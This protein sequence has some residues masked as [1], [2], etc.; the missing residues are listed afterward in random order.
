MN[1]SDPSDN[2]WCIEWTIRPF[3]IW[4]VV[5]QA[6]FWVSYINGKLWYAAFQ[7]YIIYMCILSIW[8]KVARPMISGALNGP[9]ICLWYDEW[10]SKLPKE[11]LISM[12]SCDMQL[13]NS[14]SYICV[15]LVWDHSSYHKQLDGPFHALEIIGRAAL[16]H[17][18]RI[19]IYMIYCWK[20]A[21]HSF[22]VIW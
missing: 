11:F 21:Y 20:A 15:F 2:L 5:H 3:V 12:E 4:W 9:S 10:S 1:Q 8:V 7:Q 6:S 22:P 13:L 19:H 17:I 18:L 16:T 14:I